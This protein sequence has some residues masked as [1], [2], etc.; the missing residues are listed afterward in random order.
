MSRAATLTVLACACALTM[1]ACGGK[2]GSPT[3]STPTANHPPTIASASVTPTWGI[4]SLTSHAFVGSATDPDGDTLTYTWDFADG[5]SASSASGSVTYKNANTTTYQAIF[6][7]RDSKGLSASATVPVTSV[8]IAG[9]WTGTFMG[10]AMTV[11]LTQYLGGVVTGTW[12]VPSFGLS[13]EVGP[14][15]EPGKIQAN[16]HFEL[17]FKVKQGYFTDFYYRGTIDPAGASLT[18]NLQGSGFTGEYMA[19]TKK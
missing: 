7:A 18:G 15:G 10:G 1:T 16:G 5:T 12:S 3:S 6:T 17:R 2:D 8:T 4:A 11:T 19:L 9:N 13:G 14:A